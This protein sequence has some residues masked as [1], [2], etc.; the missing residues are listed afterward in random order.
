[1][2]RALER[3]K[4]Y[5]FFGY[6]K[7]IYITEKGKKHFA[8]RVRY[9]AKRHTEKWK[10]RKRNHKLKL[11]NVKN[12][13]RIRREKPF[14][15]HSAPLNFSLINNTN[16]TLGY[17][18]EMERK[19]KSKENLEIDISK[20]DDLTPDTIA[21]LVASIN[22]KDFVHESHYRGNAPQ[23]R[24]L[25]KLFTQS[26]FY[27]FVSNMGVNKRSEEN[28]LHR[29]TDRVV[30]PVIAMQAALKG[31]K[32]SFKNEDPYE[33]LY[34]ILIEC[35]SNTNNHAN[36]DKKGKCKWW[37]YVYNDPLTN[38][39]SYSFVDLGVGIFKSAVVQNYLKNLFKG[40]LLY[41]NINIADDL[42][43]GKIQSR[44]DKDNDIRG[45]GIPQIVEHSQAPQFKSFFIITNDVKMDLKT[46][47][48]EQLDYNF[49]GTFLYW[50]IQQYHGN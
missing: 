36:L 15:V 1:M 33:P 49:E 25:Q 3:P 38:V 27:N 50:E 11:Y 42:L 9:Q 13:K 14:L 7:K 32:H 30:A 4:C 34:N 17:F 47:V 24:E 18:A 31:I 23:K 21:L 40:T 22:D 43:A 20:V 37:L 48:K 8:R 39:T 44:V 45:K 12:E 28:M 16:E 26:G 29:E 41:K 35:M 10:N 5:L 6:M 19:F 2:H 46:G